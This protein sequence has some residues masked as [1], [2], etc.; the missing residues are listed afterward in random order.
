MNRFWTAERASHAAA[1]GLSFALYAVAVAVLLFRHRPTA[2]NPSPVAAAVRLSFAQMELRAEPVAESPPREEIPVEPLPEPD[3]EPLD[4]PETEP[5]DVL[6]LPEPN[7]EPEPP[8]APPPEEAEP[9]SEFAEEARVAQQA[10][11]PDVTAANPDDLQHWI[12]QLI[13]REKRYPPAAVRAGYEG[14]F[15]LRVRVDSSGKIDSVEITGGSGH[16]LLRNSLARMI[17]GLP[18]K[19]YDRPL[20][21]PV[22]LALDFIFELE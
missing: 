3:P 5:E 2:E 19:R 18:G 1:A 15:S 4:E 16:I 12:L 8:P 7:P 6:P 21:A 17:A 11:A 22:E 13:E 14:R 10:A 9:P 20:H